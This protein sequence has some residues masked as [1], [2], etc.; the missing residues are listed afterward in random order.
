MSN[1]CSELA[2]RIWVVQMLSTQESVSVV[3]ILRSITN[4]APATVRGVADDKVVKRDVRCCSTIS[5]KYCPTIGPLIS[6]SLEQIAAKLE[7]D[8]GQMQL[9]STTFVRYDSGGFYVDHTDSGPSLPRLYSVVTYLNDE[10]VGGDTVFPLKGIR[11]K[12]VPGQ[13]VVFPS[14]ELHRGDIVR[15]GIKYIATNWLTR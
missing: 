5:A 7:I 13:A 14:D 12:P 8:L 2:P 10:F 11:V 1:S 15:G 6:R 3:D 9:S 4:W